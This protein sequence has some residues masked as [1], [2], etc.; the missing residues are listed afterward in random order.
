MRFLPDTNACVQLLR[1]R[2]KQFIAKWRS[3]L[4]EEIVLS[5]V[6]IYELRYGAARSTDPGAEH[7]RLD[8]FVKQFQSLP[9]D[10]S[11]AVRCGELR[12]ELE[13]KGQPIGPYDLQIAATALEFGLTL[14]THNT[15]EFGRISG[16]T[17][18][19]WQIAP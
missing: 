12:A 6:V 2:D 8:L 17:I 18:V 15:R 9:F 10:E 3:I 5:S 13:K 1:D 11:C 7:Q 19:D 14:V 16:L 4:S